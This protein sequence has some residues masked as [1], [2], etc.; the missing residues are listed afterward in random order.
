[1][2]TSILTKS[3]RIHWFFSVEWEEV[4]SSN[5]TLNDRHLIETDNHCISQAF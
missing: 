4:S 1:M 2:E 3:D 5:I